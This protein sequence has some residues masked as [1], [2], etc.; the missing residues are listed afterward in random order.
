MIPL[1]ALY[2]V[3]GMIVAG[4]FEG[5]TYEVEEGSEPGDL[6]G[7]GLIVVVW[8]LLSCYFLITVVGAFVRAIV[9]GIRTYRRTRR[10]R[11]AKA[12]PVKTS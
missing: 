4:I 3:V 6:A 8:P 2:L 5:I 7:L 1:I 12:K 10:L 11:H 9:F